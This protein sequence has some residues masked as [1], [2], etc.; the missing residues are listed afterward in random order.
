MYSNYPVG[1]SRYLRI[2]STYRNRILFPAQSDFEVPLPNNVDTQITG[3]I[4]SDPIYGGYPIEFGFFGPCKSVEGVFSNS[5]QLSEQASN[6]SNYYD[7]LIV[8]D[9]TVCPRDYATI[10]SYDATPTTY[11]APKIAIIDGFKNALFP[12][13]TG[14]LYSIRKEMPLAQGSCQQISTKSFK[15]T[16]SG[17][18]GVNITTPGSGYSSLPGLNSVIN[19]LTP[20]YSGYSNIPGVNSFVPVTILNPTFSSA[21]YGASLVAPISDTF[22]GEITN[23]LP[24]GFKGSSGGG[25][26][27]YSIRNGLQTSTM[28]PKKWYPSTNYSQGDIIYFANFFYY[29][30]V[31]GVSPVDATNVSNPLSWTDETIIDGTMTLVHVQYLNTSPGYGFGSSS[32]SPWKPQSLVFEGNYVTFAGNNYSVYTSGVT[33]NVPPVSV[34]TLTP[35]QNGTSWLMYVNNIPSSPP[36]VVIGMPLEIMIFYYYPV[37]ACVVY[38]NMVLTC[39]TT[40]FVFSLTLTQGGD[41]LW[42]AG[43]AKFKQTGTPAIGQVVLDTQ[44]PQ[45]AGNEWQ[46]NTMYNKGSLLWY[47]NNFYEV[48]NDGISGQ[49]HPF[50]SVS[51]N[52][53]DLLLNPVEYND[54]YK[55]NLFKITQVQP[56]TIDNKLA[57]Y[58]RISFYNP[59]TQ[60]LTLEN[61]IPI[62]AGIFNYEIEKFSYDNVRALQYTINPFLQQTVDVLY[63]ISVVSLIIPNL[64]LFSSNGINVLTTPQAQ[65]FETFPRVS[66][67]PYVIVTLKNMANTTNASPDCS[68]NPNEY[69]A[70]FRVAVVDNNPILSAP[71]SRLQ[72]N[73]TKTMRFSPTDNI[74]FTVTDPEGNVLVYA[75]PTTL[76]DFLKILVS[77]NIPPDTVFYN[78]NTAQGLGL[79]VILPPILPIEP[80]PNLQISAVFSI[81]PHVYY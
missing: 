72:G 65:P 68:N 2:D 41:G 12:G 46:A 11:G 52:N 71:F 38:N 15:L 40:G 36:T 57:Y 61:D 16:N 14:S 33:S 63:D 37:G 9:E 51:Q 55:G 74:R 53:G 58:S 64:P 27:F 23:V 73:E 47:G 10:L 75:N 7:G 80:N 25:N 32:T 19:I 56:A 49:N 1:S 77:G 76:K 44:P 35:F 39:V 48:M 20:Y 50:G 60:I 70:T 54:P 66:T 22:K 59:F 67:L 62:V 43:S 42:S 13:K 18:F 21:G 30:Q 29:V 4:A 8:V 3:D 28:T 31:G 24:M 6:S 34:A 81:R 78:T 17:I 79:G 45:I 26:S 5:V 69:S